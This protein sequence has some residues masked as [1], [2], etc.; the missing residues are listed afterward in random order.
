LTSISDEDWGAS[1]EANLNT[2]MVTARAAMPALIETRGNVLMMA[3]IAALAAAPE[4]CGYV[5]MKHGLIG[6]TKSIAR[7]FGVATLTSVVG[8]ADMRIGPNGNLFVCSYG[9]GYVLEVTTSG[10]FVSTWSQ[11]AFSRTND[12][13]FHP[14]G[15]ILVTSTGPTN[16]VFRY[17]AL[18]TQLGSFA[19][20][21]WGNPHGIE[22][23]PWNGRLLV[24]DGITSQVHEFDPVNFTELNQAFLAPAPGSKVVDLDFRLDFAPP[25]VYCTPKINSLGCIP[26]IGWL[27]TSSAT[28][29]LGFTL[30]T[31]DVVNN[32]PGL[33][34]YTSAGQAAVPFSGGTLC[35]SA[36]IRRTVAMNSG[37]NPP[38]NDCSGVFALDMNAFAVG[39]L[40]GA[41]APFLT[42]PGT[43]VDAQ[44]WGRDNGF[45]PPDNATLSAGLEFTVGP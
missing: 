17:D 5:T 36:P 39:A 22:I 32:K 10:Q 14:S 42:V 40:G 25:I 20:T 35:L 43:V 19:G 21:A 29:G 9:G 37:G 15:E 4:S 30:L 6:L 38:P 34:I 12:I 26:S 31:S 2:A 18:H 41:P 7:D 8:P 11:P 13:A 33:Y 3:S 1:V 16:C 23:S 24:V 44:C 27:G 45:S 28:A